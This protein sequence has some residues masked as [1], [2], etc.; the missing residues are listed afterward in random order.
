MRKCKSCGKSFSPA[1]AGL[2]DPGECKTCWNN[3]FYKRLQRA[4]YPNVNVKRPRKGKS[5]TSRWHWSCHPPR[6]S[7][8][9][10]WMDGLRALK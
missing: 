4:F 6:A 10:G 2:K 9:P 3:A 8:G 1:N 5:Q 7:S